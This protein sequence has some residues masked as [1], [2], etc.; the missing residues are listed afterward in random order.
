[1]PNLPKQPRPANAIAIRQAWADEHDA[2]RRARAASDSTAEWTHLERVH[3]L[4]Q[5]FAVLHVRTH[6]A[7]LSYGVRH[8]DRR[9]TT[10]QLARLL[11]AGPGTLLG[12]YPLGNTGGA[13]VS[14]EQPMDIP[15]DLRAILHGS[16]AVA[17]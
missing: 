7:M 1:M 15:S 17:S 13:N 5:P 14:A 10:G 6:V 8:R 16:R 9:E 4:S 12:R 2:A 11:V 3:I